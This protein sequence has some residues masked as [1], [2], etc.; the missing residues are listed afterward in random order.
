MQI[1]QFLIGFT[2]A[3]SHLFV[4]YTVPVSTP[5][6]ITS[7]FTSIASAAFSPS[8]AISSAVTSAAAATISTPIASWL[9]K[10]AFRAAGEEGLA[11]NVLNDQGKPFGPDA[12]DIVETV[13]REVRYRIQYET[14]SCIDT[15]GQAFAIYLNLIYLAPLTWLFVRFF[16]RSY[17]RR[18]NPKARH[19]TK[20]GR[21][22]KAAK[23]AAHGVDRELDQL[24][25][26]AEDGAGEPVE[27]LKSAAFGEGNENLER[28]KSSDKRRVSATIERQCKRF[29][30]GKGAAEEAVKDVAD[31]IRS[32]G[33]P[34][35]G[36]LRKKASEGHEKLRS[37]WEEGMDGRSSPEAAIKAKDVAL[38]G[39]QSVKKAI[40]APADE[41][42]SKLEESAEHA[43][44]K[45]KQAV[46]G[47]TQGSGEKLETEMEGGVS[48][49]SESKESK[50]AMEE[51]SD[52]GKEAARKDS[53]TGQDG[54]EIDD[55][56]YKTSAS[57][58]DENQKPAELR[59]GE[60]KGT[61]ASWED[62]HASEVKQ[63][64]RDDKKE[65]DA[66]L[67]RTE[68]SPL[69]RTQSRDSTHKAQPHSK[70]PRPKDS[71]R[72]RSPVKKAA[73]ANRVG[74]PKVNG[75]ASPVR[76]EKE[77]SQVDGATD[78]SHHLK[79]TG[80]NEPTFAQVV[81]EGESA[82]A[83]AKAGVQKN[84]DEHEE[85]SK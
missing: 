52:R 48:P 84:G 38:D 16:I 85:E 68:S 83:N 73:A 50:S 77:P 19:Q 44:Q 49:K 4:E 15:Q 47:A 8:A 69:S 53:A 24:G 1:M 40:V 29:E 13:K 70:I 45:A 59:A 56:Q 27:N 42:V 72:S 37:M 7:T 82:E 21:L 79:G 18:A 61:D 46:S 64:K 62:L 35:A 58:K 67:E 33:S 26:A 31:K 66:Q 10:L 71:S 63:Q 25:K 76:E 14:V 36:K 60:S 22:N 3:L 39:M 78:D 12:T 74:T 9:K 20:S 51:L 2:F 65:D 57:N 17:T 55:Q 54:L 41:V 6:T 43:V 34:A 5:Y 75:M 81:K 30:E 23:D 32:N 28:L 80:D 11:E